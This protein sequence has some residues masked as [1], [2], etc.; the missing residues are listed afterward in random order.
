M[1][2]MTTMKCNNKLTNVYSII[3][4]AIISLVF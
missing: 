1:M 3:I 2:M 4:I